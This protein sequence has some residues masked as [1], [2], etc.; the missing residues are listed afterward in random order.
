MAKQ[1]KLKNATIPEKIK[2]IQ[3]FQ[4]LLEHCTQPIPGHTHPDSVNDYWRVMQAFLVEVVED[5]H[6]LECPECGKYVDP[7]I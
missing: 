7:K 1:G 2:Q 6:V 3:S 4:K 5:Y